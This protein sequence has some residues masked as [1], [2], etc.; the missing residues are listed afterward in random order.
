VIIPG[1]NGS[2]YNL[3]LAD[4]TAI[5][6][7]SLSRLPG[8]DLTSITV[9]PPLLVNL[10]SSPVLL[11]FECAPE[12]L[13]AFGVEMFRDDC[14]G[15]PVSVSITAIPGTALPGDML[16]MLVTSRKLRGDGTLTDVLNQLL[17]LSAF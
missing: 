3:L 10:T 8:A 9:L 15:G 17:A 16:C 13:S 7:D 1:I 5:Y 12:A 4:L 2:Q 14:N 6:N 11:D